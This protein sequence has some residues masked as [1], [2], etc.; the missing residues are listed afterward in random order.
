MPSVM[1]TRQRPDSSSRLN[2]S[3]CR[4]FHFKPTDE[5][6]KVFLE[7]YYTA[8]LFRPA[9]LSVFLN[10]VCMMMTKFDSGV[11]RT[12]AKALL[13]QTHIHRLAMVPVHAEQL[14]MLGEVLRTG[15]VHSFPIRLKRKGD[16]NKSVGGRKRAREASKL[17]DRVVHVKVSFSVA[18]KGSVATGMN[19]CGSDADV[20]T[21]I[22]R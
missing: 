1:M 11:Q 12:A 22:D 8:G 14:Q 10:S 16:T 13:R 18:Y 2:G 4:F 6:N 20:Q 19:V 3:C 9:I 15:C 5:G 21:L 7:L 17:P